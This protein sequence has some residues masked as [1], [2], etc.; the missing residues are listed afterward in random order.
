MPSRERK[1]EYFVKMTEL[2]DNY[3]KILIITVDH[4]GS[5]QFQK[6][7]IAL[8]GSAVVLMGKNT[9]MRRVI[10]TK[11]D[12]SEDPE[13]HPFQALLGA[14]LGNMGFIFTNGDL[15]KIQDVIE[16]NR[17]PAAAKAGVMA[18]INVLVPPGPTGCDPGQT[19]WFQALNVPTKISK[20]QIEIVSELL[21]VEK[22]KRVGSSEAALLQKLG[23]KPFTYGLVLAKVYE[24]G[25][26]YDA[27]V[28]SIT[29]DDL[30]AKFL[31]VMRTVAALSLATGIPT[32]ASLPHSIGKAVR[33][34]I[35]VAV[36]IKYTFPQMEE[37]TALLN[38]PAA[39]AAPAA[40]EEAPAAEE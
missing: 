40:E 3:S 35:A 21:L 10:Q 32:L 34:C 17:V 30:K 37:W 20:G 14:V 27:K 23:I 29:E 24:N 13:N 28:L 6:I 1:A 33:R 36:E 25:S 15:S 31:T 22:G 18:E 5:S 7:R 4:V 26:I 39:A 19:S 16:E 11:I 12:E 2:L 8:R 9:L 38:P